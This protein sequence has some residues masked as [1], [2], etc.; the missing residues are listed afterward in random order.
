MNI[1]PPDPN[2]QQDSTPLYVEHTAAF[3]SLRYLSNSINWFATRIQ[4]FSPAYKRHNMHAL[5]PKDVAPSCRLK[6]SK[7]IIKLWPNSGESPSCMFRV[8]TLSN[9]MTKHS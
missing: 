8:S 3:K 5:F 7:R 1:V 4:Y 2:G 6:S 9:R